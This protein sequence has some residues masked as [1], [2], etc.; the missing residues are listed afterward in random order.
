MK[1]KS[2]GITVTIAIV[3]LIGV[4]LLLIVAAL[5]RR[6]E[7]VGLNQEI[8]YDDFAFSVLD[9]RKAV[10]LGSGASETSAVGVYYIVTVRIAN[11][12][13]RVDYTFK[14]GSAILVDDR[15]R[16]FFLSA[17]GQAGLESAES[18]QCNSPI[19]AGAACVAEVV[20]DVPKETRAS[21]LRFSEGGLVGD[22]LDVVFYGKKRIDI[23]SLQ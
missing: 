22:I 18:R 12:A 6:D 20:F 5:N 14:R 17:A 11:H 23:G 19:P 1:Q 16:E 4:S 9:V 8:K 3:V 10:S 2:R 21:Q 13:K 15:R 7:I